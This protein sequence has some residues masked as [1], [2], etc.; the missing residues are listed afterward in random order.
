M[1]RFHGP[2]K[3]GSAPSKVNAA[4][5]PGTSGNSALNLHREFFA[6]IAAGTK[7]TEYRSRTPYWR[8]R[9][10]G[11]HYDVIQSRKGYAPKRREM[12]E[13]FLGLRRFGKARNAYYAIRLG[14][15]LKIQRWPA[16][17]P[18][19]TSA[20][21]NVAGIESEF[22]ATT[23]PGSPP[24]ARPAGGTA[25]AQRQRPHPPRRKKS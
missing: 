6:Q 19:A 5:R 20:A 3:Y 23:L 25:R 12:L 24:P 4:I 22:R 16:I 9:L 13:E 17:I 11:R 1:F 10:E 8:C 18:S 21:R 14:R 7:R 2:A 15:V